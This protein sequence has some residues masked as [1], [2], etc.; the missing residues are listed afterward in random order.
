[1]EEEGRVAGVRTSNGDELRARLVIACDGRDSRFRTGFPPRVI[2]APM[3]VF[4]FR[5]PKREQPQNDSMGVFDAGRIFVLIDRGDYWQ[6]AFVFPKGGAE[7]L[8]TE[9]P[10]SNPTRRFV[11][12]IIYASERAAA[13][14][15]HLLAFS[16]GTTAQ[17]RVL[18][19]NSLVSGM[20]PML[21]RLVGNN[22]E[23]S[24]LTGPALGRVKAVE[25]QASGGCGGQTAGVRPE[26]GER[27]GL[28]G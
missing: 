15:R 19:L 27:R 5:L 1:M 3:D 21:H 9:M 14:T 28:H 10:S 17:P 22:I 13:L 18:D 7:L 6:C 4:W 26:L 11:D 2:G 12:E 23:M 25:G 8:R 16:R 24:L 20:E